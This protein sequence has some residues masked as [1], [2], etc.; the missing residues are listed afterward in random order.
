MCPRGEEKIPRNPARSNFEEK[1][2]EIDVAISET[3]MK[4]TDLPLPDHTPDCEEN[5]ERFLEI[6]KLRVRL[7]CALKAHIK[8]SFFRNIFLGI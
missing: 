3:D 8:F 5:K 2:R 7:M 1:L 6:K 4:L